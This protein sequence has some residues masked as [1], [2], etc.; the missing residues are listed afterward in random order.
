MAVPLT[1]SS[2]PAQTPYVQYVSGASQTVFPYPFEITQDSDLVCLINGVAQP[3]DSG[4]TLSGQGNTNG[5]NLTFTVGQTVGT[6]ITLYRNISI[7]RITQLAQYGTYFSAN[8]NNEFNRIYL[9]MQQLQQS[10]LPGGNQAF[11]L[12]V[13]NGNSPSPTTLLTPAAY[14]NKYLSFDGNGNPQPTVLTSS[15]SLTATIINGL[16]ANSGVLT[17]QEISAGTTPS[18]YL[19]LGQP[20][21]DVRRYGCVLDGATD[22]SIAF[23]KC[24]TVAA[25]LSAQNISFVIDG[26]M[27]LNSTIVIPQNV[28]LI[29]TANGKIKPGNTH[30]I[31][32]GQGPDAGL[33]QI[34]D[35]S[36]GGLVAWPSTGNRVQDVWGEWWGADGDAST[37][38]NNDVPI[39][40]AIAS[41]L[42]AGI[43]GTVRLG[44]GTF[45]CAGPINLA[46]LV[47]LRGMGYYTLI[48][49]KSGWS[50]GANLITANNGT[51]P[52]FDSRLE[53]LRIDGGAF[54]TITTMIA[55]T[56]WQQRC[57]IFNC[58]LAN[59]QGVGFGYTHG[60][61]GAAF[62]E[63][64]HVDIFTNNVNN[65]IGASFT[66]DASTGFL[67]LMLKQ[68]ALGNAGYDGTKTVT[69]LQIDNQ[70]LGIVDAVDIETITYG[71]TLTHGAVLTGAGIS[72]GSSVTG[73]INCGASWTG[74]VDLG[75]VQLGNA[76][77]VITDSNRAYAYLA[78]Q[79]MDGHLI[80][81]STMT[82][83]IGVAKITGGGSPTVAAGQAL[84]VCT[85][86]VANEAT[87][88]TRITLTSVDGTSTVLARAYSMDSSA[89]LANAVAVDTTHV[90]IY[91]FTHLGAAANSNI[92]IVEILHTP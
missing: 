26:P 34:F 24:L 59:F 53:Y 77:A 65:A 16:L 89:P 25:A 11:A 40:A 23:G 73:M 3:T 22:D 33:W 9:I 68:V 2:V 12:M 1:L 45:F 76:S 85:T 8:F 72:G 13:P 92:I 38:L 39:N 78:L 74:S 69:G 87:G 35:L 29:F 14:A 44:I 28:Q 36:A 37:V 46:T 62:M 31:T 70:I 66:N 20:W 50:G 56:G 48:K 18:N 58:T 32:L 51:S 86:T 90:D 21:M 57:G 5:G 15:G 84:G 61:G 79:P 67:K 42:A 17:S 10:L 82:K 71:I 6:I 60:Y 83:P 30:T 64:S 88:Q 41:I 7:A 4:Y 54:G 81:P 27:F 75:G 55:G 19:Y 49:A 52:M 91:T 43:C 80:H 47:S 63:L